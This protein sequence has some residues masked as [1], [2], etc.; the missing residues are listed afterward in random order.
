MTIYTIHTSERERLWGSGG[1][2]RA[3]MGREV[4]RS[5]AGKISPI[6]AE[7]RGNLVARQ[8]RL[9]LSD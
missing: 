7:G 4:G 6:R 1:C 8:G 5:L 3:L 2:D 9:V